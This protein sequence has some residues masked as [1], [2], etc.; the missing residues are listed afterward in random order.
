MKAKIYNYKSGAWV[1]FEKIGIWYRVA[2]YS[3]T[4]AQLDKIRLDD[5]RNAL[6]YLQSFRAIAKNS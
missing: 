4:G 6:A 5:Y 3:A 1:E 2:V